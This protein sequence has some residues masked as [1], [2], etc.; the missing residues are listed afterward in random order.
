[1]IK[2]DKKFDL[3]WDRCTVKRIKWIAKDVLLNIAMEK[4]IGSW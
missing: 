1:M 2:H 4:K 3:I